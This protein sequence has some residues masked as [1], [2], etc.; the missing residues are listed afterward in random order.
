MVVGDEDVAQFLERRTGDH[1]LMRH[2]V[3]AVNNVEDIIDNDHLRRRHT[4]LVRSWA[5][6]GTKQ[7]QPCL[8]ALRLTPPR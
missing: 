8:T 5:A 7:D 1:E 3:A 2:T 4:D 6:T